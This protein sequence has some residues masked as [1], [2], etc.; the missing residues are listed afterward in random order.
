M[1]KV[2]VLF[3]EMPVKHYF[4]EDGFPP[5]EMLEE[6]DGTCLEKTFNTKAEYEAY[7]DALKDYNGWLDAAVYTESFVDY[8]EELKKADVVY[9]V[10]VPKAIE[11]GRGAMRPIVKNIVPDFVPISQ[12]FNI[13]KMLGMGRLIPAPTYDTEDKSYQYLILDQPL[14]EE[15]KKRVGSSMYFAVA[16]KIVEQST[17]AIELFELTE[18]SLCVQLNEVEPTVLG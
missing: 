7:C 12:D 1:I 2:K 16:G 9:L 6:L 11:D 10:E 15:L 13:S 4:S 17:K 3:G 5:Q 8:D 18:V 14:P